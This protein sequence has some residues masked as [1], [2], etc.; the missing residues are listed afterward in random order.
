MIRL[1]PRLNYHFKT[2]NLLTCWWNY[3]HST[4]RF[5][6]KLEDY[7]QRDRVCL[8][9]SAST[10]IYKVLRALKP[11]VKVGVQPLT[12]PSVLK[13]IVEAGATIEFLDIN[14]QLQLSIDAVVEKK[15]HLDVLILT[16][17]FGI[18]L[19][20]AGFR[21]IVGTETLIIEDCAHAFMT[22]WENQPVGK[23]GDF[24]CFSFGRAKFPS[25]LGGGAVIVNNPAYKGRIEADKPMLFSKELLVWSSAILLKII[26]LP[27]FYAV[28]GVRLKNHKSKKSDYTTGISRVSISYLMSIW[29]LKDAMLNRQLFNWN[30]VANA[31]ET[32][33]SLTVCSRTS[34]TNGFLV[35]ALAENRERIITEFRNEGIEIGK[36]F[37]ATFD[38]LPFYG[39]VPGECPVYE[40]INQQLLTFPSHYQYPAS[41]IRKIISV[42]SH[43]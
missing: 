8:T 26:H 19:D 24:S 27:L 43:L 14:E 40:R 4:V 1:Y 36:H 32:A 38:K 35:A 33:N 31:I 11:G 39:Y 15:E 23:Q 30:C 2:I 41:S 21:A 5:K 37:V 29:H 25:S 12:C 6:K 17:L 42:L 9:S 13:A 22:K 34:T 3:S 28:L 20:V 18:P 10:G 7:F 16:H